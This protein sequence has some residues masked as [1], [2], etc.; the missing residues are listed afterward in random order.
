[1]YT[2]PVDLAPAEGRG[3]YLPVTEKNSRRKM[4]LLSELYKMTNVQEDMIKNM[5]NKFSIE[6]FSCEFKIFLE[7]FKSY[8]I[9][10]Q[11]RKDLP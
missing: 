2:T 4:V 3:E 11:T 1:M 7:I 8:L 5:V 6:I 10:A 9:L